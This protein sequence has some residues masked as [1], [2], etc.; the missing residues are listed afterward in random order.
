MVEG[1]VVIRHYRVVVI[2]TM[3]EGTV[4][5]GTVVEGAVVIRHY[6]PWSKVP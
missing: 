4:V 2:R 3:V 6:V 5:E 1:T